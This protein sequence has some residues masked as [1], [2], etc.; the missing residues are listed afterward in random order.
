MLEYDYKT[1]LT[2]NTVSSNWKYN[3]PM[4]SHVRVFVGLLVVVGGLVR[5][6]SVCYQL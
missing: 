6:R 2:L 5:R 4:N 1:H 3:F